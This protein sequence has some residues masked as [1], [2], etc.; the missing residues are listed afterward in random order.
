MFSK[1]IERLPIEVGR[2]P[3]SGLPVKPKNLNFLQF[4]KEE[5][6][7]NSRV[8]DVKQLYV[9][10]SQ[11]RFLRLLPIVFGIMPEKEFVPISRYTSLDALVMKL[12]M[13]PKNL[14]RK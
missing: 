12:G 2:T 1:D 13:V 5:R 7:L 8:K 9:K 4:V 14:F 6:K 11:S 10:S 3:S